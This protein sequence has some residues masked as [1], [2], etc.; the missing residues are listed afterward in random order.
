MF[1]ITTHYEMD[2]SNDSEPDDQI[3]SK[4][5]DPWVAIEGL[6]LGIS[7][8]DAIRRVERFGENTLGFKPYTWQT[9]ASAAVLTG[10]DVVCIART[11]DGKSA[12]FQLLAC[13]NR[14][15]HIVISLLI[16]LIEQQVW[17]S[18]DVAK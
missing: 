11:G 1:R 10:H 3:Q 16:G 14:T 6:Q 4:K 12:V 15:R 9:H 5:K 13:N 7:M 2:L 18:Q 8:R 17:T